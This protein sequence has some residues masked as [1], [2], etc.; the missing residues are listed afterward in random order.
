M[1]YNKG[2]FTIVPSKSARRGLPPIQQTVYTWLSDYADDNNKSFPSRKKLAADCGI[3][4]RTLDNALIALEEIGLVKK[5][6]RYIKNEKTSN[7]YE[8][9]MV[10]GEVEG[11]AY[12][13]RPSAGNDTTPRAADAHRTQTNT[14]SLTLTTSGKEL[15][16]EEISRKYYQV[17]KKY[18]LPVRNHNNI[19]VK[20]G[21]AIKYDD[22]E[23]VKYLN[24]LLNYDYNSIKMKFKP[25]LNEGLDI[26]SKRLQIINQIKQEQESKPTRIEV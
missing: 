21:E 15:P 25:Q 11:R 5:T 18:G 6:N 4:L 9:I 22:G 13:A 16:G 3:T 26:F 19:R 17:I 20:L 12:N 10:E 23:Y 24:F 2:E 1:K 14:N 8:I 7:L